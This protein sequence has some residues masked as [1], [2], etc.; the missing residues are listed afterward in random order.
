M[1][2]LFADFT[3]SSFSVLEI[4]NSFIQMFPSKIGPKCVSKIKFC[5][6]DLPQKE[7][8]KPVFPTGSDE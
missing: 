8:T 4:D 3:K 6:G 7:I 1:R 5:I 2:H